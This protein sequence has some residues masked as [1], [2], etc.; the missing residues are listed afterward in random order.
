MGVLQAFTSGGLAVLLLLVSV[1][2]FGC[3][4]SCQLL[5]P[6]RCAVGVAGC[7]NGIARCLFLIGLQK[8]PVSTAVLIGHLDIA[9]SLEIESFMTGKMPRCYQMVTALAVLVLCSLCMAF[10]TQANLDDTSQHSFEVAYA[11]LTCC[12]VVADCLG[13]AALQWAFNAMV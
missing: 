9:I 6:K 12:A 2:Y 5:M 1:L 10:V 13:D 3:S 8:L 4:A 7:M 11:L